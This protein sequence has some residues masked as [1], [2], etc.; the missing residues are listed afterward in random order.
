MRLGL[1]FANFVS[2]RDKIW[3][4]FRTQDAYIFHGTVSIQGVCTLINVTFMTQIP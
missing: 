1:G 2:M 4:V 3:V